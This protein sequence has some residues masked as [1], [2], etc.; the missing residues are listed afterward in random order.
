MEK[1]LKKRIGM[2]IML[3]LIALSVSLVFL[4]AGAN[5]VSEECSDRKIS[6]EAEIKKWK[7][8]LSGISKEIP[9]EHRGE[10]LRMTS[11][12]PELMM[13]VAAAYRIN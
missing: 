8:I 5:Q 9:M 6:R 3:S 2:R 10:W 12:N 4:G 13:K 1:I 7:S 11:D